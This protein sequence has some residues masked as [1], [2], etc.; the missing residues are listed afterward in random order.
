[1][2]GA[3]GLSGFPK[4]MVPAGKKKIFKT[5]YYLHAVILNVVKDLGAA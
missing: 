3:A 1:M 2:D 4:V 5:N